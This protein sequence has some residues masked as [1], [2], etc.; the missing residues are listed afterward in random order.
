MKPITNILLVAALVCYVFL[1]FYDIS[2]QGGLTGLEFT[3]GVISRTLSVRGVTFALLPFIAG[4]LGTGFNCLKNRYWSIGSVVFIIAWLVFYIFASNFHEFS[5]VHA[6]DV[7]P[8]NDLG[9]GFTITGVGI[10]FTSSCILV[11]LS[12]VSAIISLMPF[13]FNEAIERA[14]DD[15]IDKSLEGSRKHIKAL[16]NEVREEWNK[17]EAKTKKHGR[18]A[19][20]TTGL[21]SHEQQT[22]AEDNSRYMPGGDVI[23][24]PQPVIELDKEDDS[25]F[26]PGNQG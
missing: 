23:E 20:T 2:F 16:G 18:Y 13:K 14:V 11:S 8:G 3:A 5:L 24:E 10:G 9:E 1:P 15:T 6:P 7:A 21:T 22:P 12:L 4:F 25:R 26:M 17:I 19:E